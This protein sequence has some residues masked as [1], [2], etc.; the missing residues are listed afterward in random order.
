VKGVSH[1]RV[2]WE[3]DFMK[4]VRIMACLEPEN[5]AKLA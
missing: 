5:H 1:P 2:G 4:A 3:D